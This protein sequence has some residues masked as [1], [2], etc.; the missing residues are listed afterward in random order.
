MAWKPIQ[1]ITLIANEGENV[2]LP[3]QVPSIDISADGTI[4]NTVLVNIDF[5]KDQNDNIVTE[6]R[7][8]KRAEF[9][10][11]GTVVGY[12]HTVYCS[13]VVGDSHENPQSEFPTDFED[14]E[15][16]DKP[17]E[18]GVSK[19]EVRTSDMPH[20]TD[21]QYFK[22]KKNRTTFESAQLQK[23]TELMASK[24]IMAKDINHIRNAITNT[25]LFCLSLKRVLDET[26]TD[27]ENIGSGE[28]EV[29]SGLVDN[30]EK[31]GKKMQFRTLRAGDNISISTSGDEVEISAEVPEQQEGLGS[32]MCAID[33][34]K[35]KSLSTCAL[36]HNGQ[37]LNQNNGA[38]FR[39]G[40]GLG[41]KVARAGMSRPSMMLVFGLGDGIDKAMVNAGRI[42]KGV[43]DFI[44]EI[45][46]AEG[47]YA[48]IRIKGNYGRSSTDDS[49]GGI[50]EIYGSQIIQSNDTSFSRIASAMVNE[51]ADIKN[52]TD[53]EVYGEHSLC[54]QGVM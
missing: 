38:F 7:T 17:D 18:F 12:P 14:V 2:T 23:L 3:R 44:F 8:D 32:D 39:F 30:T 33:P 5:W 15:D 13:V 34:I 40:E 6:A 24:I 45:K 16:D 48:G 36:T 35:V 27:G 25:Q 47:K 4:Q 21:Y 28:G 54:G 22:A 31:F 37:G 29:Y 50:V 10:Y 49:G 1:N 53:N 51:N 9:M 43:R 52:Y 11:Y 41:I 26:V 46:Y 20:I 19:E 42:Y